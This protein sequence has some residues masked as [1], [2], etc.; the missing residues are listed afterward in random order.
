MPLIK[1]NLNEV[2]S[3]HYGAKKRTEPTRLEDIEKNRCNKRLFESLIIAE[4]N[5]K[6]LSQKRSF[7]R[8][9]EYRGVINTTHPFRRNAMESGKLPK[10][11]SRL[12]HLL[13]PGPLAVHL[14]NL[15]IIS[16]GSV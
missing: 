3:P 7:V 11:I 13:L 16:A 1:G 8:A 15:I 5:R 2:V 14:V 12:L 9:D 6:K 10:N 4:K